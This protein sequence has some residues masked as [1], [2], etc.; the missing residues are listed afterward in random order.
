MEPG[1]DSPSREYLL[2]VLSPPFTHKERPLHFDSI[3]HD[4]IPEGFILSQRTRQGKPIY[5]FVMSNTRTAL[6]NICADYQFFIPPDIDT[7]QKAFYKGAKRIFTSSVAQGESDLSNAKDAVEF[8]NYGWLSLKFLKSSVKEMIFARVLFVLSWNLMCRIS[9]VID[10]CWSH[11]QWRD[12]ALC[13]FFQSKKRPSRAA[14]S[15]WTTRLRESFP[16]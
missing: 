3:F 2:S 13:V 15:A 6:F 7:K 5:P 1:I 8:A 9:I 14:C 11:I 16:S 4:R 12:D 10:L